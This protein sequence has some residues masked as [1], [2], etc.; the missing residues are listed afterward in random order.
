MLPFV[1]AI[2]VFAMTMAF[3]GSLQFGFLA[4][5][6]AVVMTGLLLLYLLLRLPFDSMSWTKGVEGERK[7]A[8]FIEPLLDAGYVV[9]NDRLFVGDHDRSWVIDQVY[10]ELTP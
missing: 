10:R 7:T 6:V 2:A 1:V 4:A 9:R 3:F 8:A 5:S